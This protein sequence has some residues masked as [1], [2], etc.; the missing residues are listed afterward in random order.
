MPVHDCVPIECLTKLP[1]LRT[2]RMLAPADDSGWALLTQLEALELHPQPDETHMGRD[3]AL[4]PD[5]ISPLAALPRL[6]TLH[7]LYRQLAEHAAELAR[8][9]ALTQ[10]HLRCAQPKVAQ[11][12]RTKRSSSLDSK[13]LCC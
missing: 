3:D 9:P 6:H 13:L 1:G 10:L 4:L 11:L 12:V 2:L 8:F 5:V 7:V